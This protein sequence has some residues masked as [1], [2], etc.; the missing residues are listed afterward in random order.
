MPLYAIDRSSRSAPRPWAQSAWLGPAE[1]AGCRQ[2]RLHK[3]LRTGP[4]AG[5]LGRPFAAA[6]VNLL[7]HALP[8]AILSSVPLLYSPLLI[9]CCVSTPLD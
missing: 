3:R 1:E 5:R 4:A 7:A 2:L 6:L 9:P 8:T